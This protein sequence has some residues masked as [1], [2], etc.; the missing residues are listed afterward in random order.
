MN[1]D[2]LKFWKDPTQVSS[3]LRAYNGGRLY[4]F[5][6]PDFYVNQTWG[7][8]MLETC[9][10]YMKKEWSILELGCNTG[11]TLAYMKEHGF[12]NVMGVEINQKAIDIGRKKFKLLKDVEIICSPLEDVIKDINHFDMIYAGGVFMHLPYELDW[13]FE[14]IS[15]HARHLIMTAENET[16]TDFYKFARNYKRIFEQWGWEQ[17]EEEKGSNF[18]PLPDSTVKRI[19]VK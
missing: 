6:Q 4:K 5:C 15:N 16:E 12:N 1:F 18:P 8:R 3:E 19:F 17:V 11:K 13:V 10:S 14:E 9:F 7:Q 2:R